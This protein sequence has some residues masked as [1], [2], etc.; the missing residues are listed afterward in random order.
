MSASGPSPDR[1]LL[2]GAGGLGCAVAEALVRA[3]VRA[4]TVADDDRVDATTLHRQLCYRSSDV[5]SLK[6]DALARALAG[7]PAP[8][9]ASPTAPGDAARALDLA[10]L[11]RRLDAAEATTLARSHAVV[12][13][14]TDGEATKLMLNDACRAAAVPLV[15]GGA[16]GWAG[17]VAV[18]MPGGPCLR[19]LFEA[20]PEVSPEAATCAAAGVMGPL[21]GV[22]GAL[23]A[24][25]V[26][27]LLQAP[28]GAGAG[29]GRLLSY[30]ARSAR[31][32]TVRFSRRCPACTA[33]EVPDAA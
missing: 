11:P 17:Q 25:A 21:P 24:L 9:S 20:P 3:G 15:H 31:F 13:D 19:C 1:V 14:A 2:V 12:V 30:D 8:T 32:R 5:G 28:R 16:L 29:Q 33:V 26:L 22:I 10:T 23:Q 7:L 6:V 27:R 18:I 4:L